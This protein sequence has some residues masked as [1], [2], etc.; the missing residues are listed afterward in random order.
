M[1][2][3]KYSTINLDREREQKQQLLNQINQ[4]RRGIE[5]VRNQIR[6]ALAEATQGVKAFFATDAQEA[7]RWLKSVDS[8]ESLRS[9]SWSS[10]RS[11]LTERSNKLQSLASQGFTLR[12]R[13]E[14]AFIHRAGELR[15]EGAKKIFEAES[16][17][18]CGEELIRTWFGSGEVDNFRARV[19]QLREEL[20]GDRLEQVAQLSKSLNSDLA[21]KLQS[22][23]VNESKHQSRLYVLKALRQV[24]ANMGFREL[25]KPKFSTPGDRN[26]CIVLKVDTI[27]RGEVTFYLSLEA[28][29]ADS[30][31]S[32]THCF[33]E[34][35]RLSKQ[36]A[37][38]FGVA[39][40]FKIGGGEAAPKLKR[41]GELE[42]PTGA[43]SKAD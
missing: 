23:E 41:K 14:E 34:F 32:Q 2:G 21:A 12:N 35:G 18:S 24:A 29:E 19:G 15:A 25:G 42:E 33:E 8:L 39:T 43:A 6:N 10:N 20:E 1:S 7:E 28:I 16:L 9:G 37:E 40:E 5:G 31:I 26:S 11:K 22:A 30:C 17:I 4:H 3:R 38:T 27:N 36:L 13:V